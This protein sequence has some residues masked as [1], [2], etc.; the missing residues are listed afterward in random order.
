MPVYEFRCSDCGQTFDKLY[1]RMISGDRE[2]PPCPVCGSANTSRLVSLFAVHGP[3]GVDAGQVAAEAAQADR[4]ASI[5][6]K[7]QINK[8]R[9]AKK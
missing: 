9:G 8:W 5:T 4:E 7:D 6:S 2:A 1:R 3:A